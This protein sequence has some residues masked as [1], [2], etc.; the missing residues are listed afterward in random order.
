[1]L[2]AYGI[3]ELGTWFGY[4]ALA[5]SVYD[6]THS[7]IATAGLFIA[8]GLLP[9]ALAPLLVTRI[10]RSSR[11]GGL[12][13]LYLSQATITLG[14]AALVWRFSLAGVLCL[15]AID[16]VAAVAATALIRASAAQ[17][18]A[19]EGPAAQRQASAVLNV[20]FMVA[21][22][23]GP[24]LGGA[25]VHAAGG[26]AA[27]LIDAGSFALAGGLLL[28]FSAHV[29]AAAGT[30]IKT[31]IADA[32]RHVQ[33]LPGLRTLLLTEAIAIVFFA[34]VEPVEVVYAKAT[35]SAG[36]LG[37]GLLLGFWGGG[38][39]LGAV[40]FARASM[41]PLGSMLTVG[42]LCVGLAYLG[43]A[44]SPSLAP[45]CVAA[46]IGGLGNGV[47]WPAMVSSVQRLTPSDM[48]GRL[49]SAIGSIT[50][51]C[52]AIGFALGGLIATATSTRIAMLCAGAVA[53]I[54]TSAFLRLWLRGPLRELHQPAEQP[55]EALV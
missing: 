3:N 20:V 26:P 12:A 19:R 4:V 32:V 44:V 42:T 11:R 9:A 54:A 7:A 28:R 30:S 16:G 21:F 46:V 6:H 24:A 2:V 47:Q 34:S 18:S 35:L 41:R 23:A 17:I 39:A 37:L 55:S 25:L 13:A 22:A 45:A 50:A 36:D 52:P 1:M 38:A 51:L 10:E 8:R 43:F 53:T 49:M 27:L 48:Q 14:L 15:V 29:T 40:V 31:R 5:V 33:S